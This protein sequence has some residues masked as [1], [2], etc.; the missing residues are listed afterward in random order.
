MAV[1]CCEEPT[2]SDGFCGVTEIEDNGGAT[3]RFVLAVVEPYVA[4]IEV[5][6]VERPLATP[7]ALMD[8]IEGTLEL[9]VTNAVR[10]CVEPLL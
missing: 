8:A 9:Q 4:V 5:S 7:V 2:V 10:S 6:P 1:S 3:L